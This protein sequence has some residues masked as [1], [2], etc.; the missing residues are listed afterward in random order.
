MLERNRGCRLEG[1]VGLDDACIRSE[2]P[3]RRCG[4]GSQ[5]KREILAAVHVT[6]DGQPGV[7]KPN[8]VE[9]FCRDVVARCGR[10]T[11]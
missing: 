10:E 2:N 5:N 9:G 7:M 11:A 6:G 4:R 3:S 8:L 1:T